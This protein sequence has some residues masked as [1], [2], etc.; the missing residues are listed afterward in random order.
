M[1]IPQPGPKQD[2]FEARKV[3]FQN[4]LF[5]QEPPPAYLHLSEAGCIQRRDLETR[6]LADLIV[7]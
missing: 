1:T 3:H 7:W 4:K 2:K 5:R 6:E